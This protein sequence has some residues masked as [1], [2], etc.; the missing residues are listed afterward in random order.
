MLVLRLACCLVQCFVN[1]TT[2]LLVQLKDR[3]IKG[4]AMK[5]GFN[6]VTP[7]WEVLEQAIERVLVTLLHSLRSFAR[8][9]TRC[10]LYSVLLW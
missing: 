5:D 4:A 2:L 3:I 6:T 8:D 10:V 7:D 1:D 9:Q